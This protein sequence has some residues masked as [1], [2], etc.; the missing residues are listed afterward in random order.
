MENT[1]RYYEVGFENDGIY[2]VNIITSNV[3][4]D[5]LAAVNE[6]AERHAQR[7]GYTVAYVAEKPE[8]YV[9][10]CKRKGMPIYPIDAEAQCK[11]GESEDEAQETRDDYFIVNKETGKLELH[12]SRDTY[13]ALDDSAKGKI[14]SNF[15]WGRRSGCWISRCK[16]PNLYQ[17]K[18]VANELGLQDAGK[19]GERLSFAEQMERKAERAERRAD[20]YEARSEAAEKRGQVLQKPINDM[21]GDIAFFTQPNINTSAGRAFTR[22][23]ERMWASFERGFE[24]FNKSA[25][26]KDRAETAR[27]T[28][29]QKELQSKG[30]VQRRIAERESDIRKLRKSIEEYESFIPAIEK[31]ETPRDH[32]GWEVKL[33]MN[34]VSE[35]LEIWLDRLEAKLDE[36]GF[37]QDCLDALGGV[38]FSKANLNKG[39]M[40]VISRYR[41][42]VRF[43]RGG[44]KNFTYEFTQPHMTL[45]NGTPMRGQAAYAE[46]ERRAD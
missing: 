17:A 35:Q 34:Q 21:H 24:E 10:E 28:A 41:D 11:Y 16:E 45:A 4:D 31:G 9:E 22:R 30:F 15:L 44:P 37:Y 33:T 19:T 32:H 7:Y 6:T 14:R 8:W 23:R 39:D 1:T 13:M 42:P 12:F 25:Y 40:I 5:D 38:A 2:S 3:G 27:A 26:W 43:L 36:L 46:I 18:R 29:S 20:R